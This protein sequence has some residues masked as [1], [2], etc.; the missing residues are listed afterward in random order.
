MANQYE[1]PTVGT[2]NLAGPSPQSGDAQ[3]F[4]ASATKQHR[5]Y[6]VLPP[7][8]GEKCGLTESVGAAVTGLLI[9]GLWTLARLLT[10]RWRSGL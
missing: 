2:G 1:L 5:A 8:A 6:R 10:R 7:S 3:S 9:L 4:Q